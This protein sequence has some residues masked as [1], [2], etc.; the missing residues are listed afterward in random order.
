VTYRPIGVTI[1]AI[2]TIIF[3]V[4]L[5]FLFMLLLVLSAVGGPYPSGTSPQL[6]LIFYAPLIL[7]VSAF[8][9][10]SGMLGRSRYAWYASMMFWIVFVLF[11]VWCYSFMGVWHWMFYLESGDWYRL[12]SIA[13]ILALPSPFVYAVGCSIYFLTKTPR[14]YF[15]R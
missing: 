11:F 1:V 15:A 5:L 14:E 13:R 3:G 6:P 7:S 4:A 2:L 10:S 9:V 12:L 8:A